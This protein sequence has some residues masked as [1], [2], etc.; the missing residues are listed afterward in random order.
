MMDDHKYFI[1]HFAKKN[2]A[3]VVYARRGFPFGG[4]HAKEEIRYR[5]YIFKDISDLNTIME[6]LKEH[7]FGRDAP[8]FVMGISEGGQAAYLASSK[9]KGLKGVVGL[10]GVSDY[11]DWYEWI[12]KEYPKYPDPRLTFAA[13]SVRKIFGCIPEECRDRYISLSPIHHVQEIS[14]PVMIEHGGK[15]LWVPVRQANRFA[16]ALQEADKPHEI[17][18]YPNEGHLL[19]FFSTPRFGT[20][21]IS[22]W[23]RPQ[24]WSNKNS[25]DVL[26]KILNFLEKKL[27]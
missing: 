18:I 8:I 7:S 10:N 9:I 4:G 15:D 27:K 1:E 24:V 19:F 21:S 11:L 22:D 6:Q 17:Y 23:L 16:K 13:K 20:G 3:G 12:L 14:C 5:D 26:V 2:F 25:Q